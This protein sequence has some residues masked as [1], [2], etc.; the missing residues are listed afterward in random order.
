M[1]HKKCGTKRN[2]QVVYLDQSNNPASG[3]SLDFSKDSGVD[4]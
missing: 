2:G 3:L 1:T 4:S